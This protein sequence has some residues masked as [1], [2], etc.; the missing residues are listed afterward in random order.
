MMVIGRGVE[1]TSLRDNLLGQNH[2]SISVFLVLQSLK[3]KATFK[4]FFQMI[5][6]SVPFFFKL[7]TLVIT[8]LQKYKMS[9]SIY[10]LYFYLPN[11]A[12]V[13]VFRPTDGTT[14]IFH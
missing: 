12:L 10:I 8:V 11:S 6:A 9:N 1:P 5:R 4:T 2:G 14:R 3:E 13:S 7:T